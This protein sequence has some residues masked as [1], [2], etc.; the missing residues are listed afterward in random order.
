MSL[1]RVLHVDDEPD[2]GEVVAMSLGLDA[3]METR[4]CSSG[5]EAIAAAAEW[6]PDIILLDV[7]MPGMDGPATLAQLRADPVT[8][9]IPVI[10][11]TARAQARELDIFRAIGAAG[12]IAKPFDPMTLAA[13]V[14]THL[15]PVA[16][17]ATPPPA[18]FVFPTG[19]RS[20]FVRRLQ[21]DTTKL[22]AY[23]ATLIADPSSPAA[24][25][26]IKDIAHRLA[27]ASGLFGFRDVSEAAA[28]LEETVTAHDGEAGSVAE[29]ATALDGLIVCVT[30]DVVAKAGP[31][32]APINA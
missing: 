13:Q 21:D 4:S 6:S 27:G 28:A 8:A 25:T 24:R 32:G 5:P 19:I 30:A 2:I 15:L 23:R 17:A 12:I 7:M 10:F 14:R 11:M 29:I 20:D 1:I 9:G 18:P 31:S 22:K 16:T 26:A 3:D